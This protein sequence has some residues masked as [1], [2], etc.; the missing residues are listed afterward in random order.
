VQEKPAP[1]PPEKPKPDP[2]ETAMNEVSQ[3]VKRYGTVFAGVKDEATADKAV[4]EIGRMTARLRELTAE[5]SKL[6]PRPVQEKFAIQLQNDLTQL[7]TAQLNNPD[8]QRV[9]SDPDLGLKFIAAQQSFVTEG[10]LPL[11]HALAS[12]QSSATIPPSEP[13][14]ASPSAAKP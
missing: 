11:G 7:S 1:P 2:L 12:S 4:Q 8:M 5:I 6:P 9:L 3:I 14:A 13:P 10:L